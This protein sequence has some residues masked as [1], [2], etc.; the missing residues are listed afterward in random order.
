MPS[1]PG[2]II[3]YF[4]FTILANITKSITSFV[5][6]A[7]QWQNK[8]EQ[9]ITSTVVYCNHALIALSQNQAWQYA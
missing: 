2:S 3:K 9:Q 4:S 1:T 7:L 5:Q 6:L 8:I